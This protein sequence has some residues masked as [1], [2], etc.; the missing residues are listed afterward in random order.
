MPSGAHGETEPEEILRR[1]VARDRVHSAYLLSGTGERPAAV[2]HGFARALVCGA[3]T[4][5]ACESCPD[6]HKSAHDEG[7]VA[8]DGK[9]RRGPTYRHVG[10]HPD[11]LWVERG[12]DD[13]RITIG[14]VR[15]MQAALRLGSHEGGRRA[16]VIAGAE[17]LNP[18]AQNA[19]LRLLEEPPARTSIVLVASRASAILATIRSRAVRIRFPQEP[20][21][22]LRDP[23]APE[24]VA[25]IVATLDGLG[26]IPIG[27]LLDLAE[28]YRGARAVAAESVTELLDVAARWLADEVKTRVARGESP[29]ER[30][31]DAYRG[32][33]Q[34]RRELIQRNANPQMVAERLLLGLQDAVA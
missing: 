29:S 33:Q 16:A 14:Q 10:D 25:E 12:A 32:L 9:G 31:L 15:D 30:A 4:G 5:V 24:S 23:D 20:E 22:P 3:R 6:C 19:L 18:Q 34:L 21:T 27:E 8:I 26:A 1:A 7:G 2:A 11:L 13:T 17:W 28:R